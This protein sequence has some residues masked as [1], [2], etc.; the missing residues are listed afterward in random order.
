MVDTSNFSPNDS[1][2]CWV[3]IMGTKSIMEESFEKAANFILRFHL[4]CTEAAKENRDVR[5]YPLMDGAFL[6][7]NKIE[8]LKKVIN[9]IFQRLS[10]YFID[11]DPCNHLFVIRGSIAKGELAHGEEIT[12]E[13]CKEIA[14]NNDYK[15]NLLF[16]LP[17]IQAFKAEEDAPPFGVFIHESARKTD[18][19]KGRYY[20]WCSDNEMRTALTERL[21]LYF[22]WCRL[23]SPYLRLDKTKISHY[24]ELVDDYFSNSSMSIKDFRS[25]N[26]MA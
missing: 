6:T 5:C 21:H 3:D 15:K 20:N 23:H 16:G 19:L 2:V 18:G 7:T 14:S 8:K 12:T 26:K 24:E 9:T 13:V 22:S 10:A 17:M 1:Y 11:T 4:A 25:I